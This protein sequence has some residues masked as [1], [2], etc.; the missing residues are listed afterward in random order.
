MT[1][2]IFL[3][4]DTPPR[5]S[6]LPAVVLRGLSWDAQLGTEITPVPRPFTQTQSEAFP[7]FHNSAVGPA[8]IKPRIGYSINDWS[9]SSH[10]LSRSHRETAMP[11]AG[12]NLFTGVAKGRRRLRGRV[13]EFP[14]T[15]PLWPN[16]AGRLVQ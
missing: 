7:L 1:A 10:W 2:P 4:F 5:P 9:P 15:S 6:T 12:V 13:T 11:R 16:L 14:Y 3:P 8:G